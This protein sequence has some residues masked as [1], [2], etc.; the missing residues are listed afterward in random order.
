MPFCLMFEAT[1]SPVEP[2]TVFSLFGPRDQH[3]RALREAFGVSV[4]HRDG[5]IRIAGAET[6]VAQ[7]TSVL[8]Q[9][10]AIAERS[11]KLEP[12]EVAGTIARA[13][14]RS[15]ISDETPIDVI[16]PA[17]RVVPRTPGQ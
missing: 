16:N 3:V 15:E 9:L 12:E 2:S 13:S 7:A 10:K 4:V 14:G 1:I 17:R 6:A 8:E 5:E 11:G